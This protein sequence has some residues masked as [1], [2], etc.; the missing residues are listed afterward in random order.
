MSEHSARE[1][2]GLGR[3]KRE[4]RSCYHEGNFRSKRK[5]SKVLIQ[6]G[7]KGGIK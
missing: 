4:G 6:K 3:D 2:L 7:G 1:R 5:S